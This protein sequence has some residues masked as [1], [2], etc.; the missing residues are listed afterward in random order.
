MDALVAAIRMS[1]ASARFAPP[2][3]A[4]PFTAASTGLAS[5][6]MVETTCAPA[7][8]SASSVFHSWRE[9]RSCMY[10]MSAPAQNAR[11]APVSTSAPTASSSAAARVTSASSSRMR[12][13][14]AFSFSGRFKVI[15]PTRSWRSKRTRALM[16]GALR[17]VRRS[18]SVR[19]EFER[20]FYITQCGR[21]ALR[22]S[23]APP[24]APDAGCGKCRLIAVLQTGNEVVGE[25]LRDLMRRGTAGRIVPARNPVDRSEDH[26]R[27]QR[28]VPYGEKTRPHAVAENGPE[29][30]VDPIAL[31]DDLLPEGRRERLHFECPRGAVQ[32]IDE[33]VHER[34]DKAVD[35][36]V[37]WQVALLDVPE[38][39]EN[40]SKRVVVADV[41]NLFFVAEV[42]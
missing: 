19:G 38:L 42:V 24:N 29:S 26:E 25:H 32:D 9:T 6:S 2:P 28:W 16:R 10:P 34:D 23:G 31:G 30:L 12:S 20:A 7:T 40:Q 27:R 15:R 8:T 36:S 22:E 1:H 39:L 13:A 33:Q 14:N 21:L 17:G 5:P 3:A 37:R 18:F 4:A 35:L 11:P 41:E